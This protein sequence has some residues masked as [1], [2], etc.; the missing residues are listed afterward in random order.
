MSA[1]RVAAL[2]TPPLALHAFVLGVGV[3]IS[4]CDFLGLGAVHRREAAAR[5]LVLLIVP[6]AL[7]AIGLLL[8]ARVLAR[9]ALVS[10]LVL[11]AYA[12]LAGAACGLLTVRYVARDAFFRGGHA[13]EIG[14]IAGGVALP[15]VALLWWRARAIGGSRPGTPRD[16]SDARAPWIVVAAALTLPQ[17][18]ISV[19]ARAQPASRADQSAA[20]GLL[21]V[22]ALAL[23]TLDE[24][25]GTRAWRDEL[26]RD[27]EGGPASDAE[28]LLLD[29]SVLQSRA[30]WALGATLTGAVLVLAAHALGNDGYTLL[31]R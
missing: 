1:A 31:T 14:A 20:L 18:A 7:A 15:I 22:V 5:A 17:V 12:P 13:G 25:R 23:L 19:A 6:L 8:S 30:R 10:L 4:A 29:Q 2:R 9:R 11:A 28:T 26:E 21:A 16:R 3:A 24:W 27:A